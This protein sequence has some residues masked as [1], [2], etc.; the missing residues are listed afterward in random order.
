MFRIAVSQ[1]RSDGSLRRSREMWTSR[2]W[3]LLPTGWWFLELVVILGLWAIY[4]RRS[5]ADAT[6]GGRPLAVAGVLLALHLFN[7][8]WLS[9]L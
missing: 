1:P 7:S 3:R 5:R 6:F 4:W 9:Q 2:V 8:Q